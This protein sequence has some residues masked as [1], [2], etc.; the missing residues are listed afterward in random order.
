MHAT[1]SAS[2]P[3]WMRA[4]LAATTA[5]QVRSPGVV[6]RQAATLSKVQPTA[7]VAPDSQTQAGSKRSARKAISTN[8]PTNSAFLSATGKVVSYCATKPHST[9]SSTAIS[10]TTEAASTGRVN[11]PDHANQPRNATSSA[12]AASPSG[13]AAIGASGA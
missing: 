9:P 2:S 13:S 6:L 4:V 5:S 8:T 7:A 3:G 1:R 11:C 10:A 12:I